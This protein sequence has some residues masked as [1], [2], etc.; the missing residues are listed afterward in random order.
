MITIVFS[1]KCLNYREPGHPE[2]PERV[3]NSYLFLKQ[4][5]FEL[6]EP[7]PC[8][9]EDLLLVHSQQMVE[10]VKNLPGLFEIA[11]LSAGGAIKACEL[12]LKNKISFSLLRPPGHHATKNN[13]GGFCYFNNIAIAVKKA[14]GE[15]PERSRKIAIIDIDCH[16]GNGTEDILLGEEKVL[17]VSLHQNPL[18]PGTGLKSYK[19]CLNFPLP[20]GTSEKRYLEVLDNAL[21]EVKKFNPS[22]I[23]VS[24]GFD[25]YKLDP[26][27]NMELE[28]ESYK[29]IGE[30]IKNLGKPV[31]SVLEGGYSEDLPECIYE[32]LQGAMD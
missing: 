18:Y 28:K 1:E 15:S 16:H 17:Y 25:T 3:Q 19:N 29:K 12:A 22:L 14:L 5:G 10:S 9:K 31:F 6:V 26:I 11:K 2:S 8:S 4:K 7:E 32:Y 23:T 20:A 27:T 24:A 30:R 21:V 13:V